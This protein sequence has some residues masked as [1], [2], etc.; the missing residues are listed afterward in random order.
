MSRWVRGKV[1]PPAAAYRASEVDEQVV[2][3]EW[4]LLDKQGGQMR[5]VSGSE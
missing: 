2:S 3:D 5:L 1:L 4:L